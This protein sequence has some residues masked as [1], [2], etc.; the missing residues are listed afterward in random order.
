MPDSEPEA[1]PDRA[2]PNLPIGWIAQWDGNSRKYYFVQI[3]TGVSTWEVPTEAAPTVPSPGNTPA[4]HQ[5][6]F[7]APQDAQAQT[8]RGVDGQEGERGLG[9]M[10]MNMLL[11]SNKPQQQQHSSGLGGLAS[12]FLGGG[13]HSNSGHNQN[14]S[15]NSGGAAGLV[16]KLAGNFLGG[17][18]KPHG[19]Q[20][21]SST[22]NSSHNSA[23]GGLGSLLGGQQSHGN[24]GGS[25]NHSSGMGGLGGLLGGHG[26]SNQQQGYG[27]SSG[28]SSQGGTYSGQAPPSSYNPSASHHSSPA[29]YGQSTGSYGGP[30]GQTTGTYGTP[31]H[32]APGQQHGQY[33]SSHNTG[34][35]PS[36]YGGQ[37][38][39]ASSG[40]QYD[41]YS[42]HQH[43]QYGGA[44]NHGQPQQN[45]QYAA[46]QPGQGSSYGQQGASAHGGLPQGGASHGGPQ[47]G[48]SSYG[49]PGQEELTQHQY[50]QYDYLF[51]LLLIGDS[52]V[53][54]SCLLLRFADD[55]YTESYI[56]TIG[57]DFKIRTIELDGKT[58]KLQIW[59]TAGQE[60]FR[61]IT[62]S[63]YRGAHGICVVY[64]VTDMDSFN[65]VKQWLQEIDRYATEGVNKLLVG[66]KSDMTDK[67]VVE[68]NVAKEFADSLGI[69]F[70]ET[71]A[72]NASN[73]EQAF[74]TMARQIKERM[75]NTT[76]NNKPTVQVGQGSTVQSGSA[77]GCC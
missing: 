58:V 72:K 42:Q 70:L 76:V 46:Y 65:N 37:P 33:Q 3:S 61:T 36:Q 67:K 19:Q 54:K 32:S 74:L 62:S 34:A 43:N 29:P 47:Y 9:G 68:Y 66:N 52:G 4:Q 73:V 12:Q 59:D 26:S 71:S 20:Q 63:Y 41:Q 13:S 25:S 53:G 16:G 27:Y 10:A 7:P 44:P 45:S 15:H 77:G 21:G 48:Q 18:N 31:S 51:K 75:G 1:G 6:P 50:N 30:S 8:T 69:P 38:S 24:T 49:G 60:R 22:G 55:T 28:G 23:L 39:H 11:N 35:S 57:V 17:Q 5:N 2:P 40:Y 64:D 56:S 14:Q